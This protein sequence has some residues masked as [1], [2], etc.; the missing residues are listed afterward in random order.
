M[1]IGK[2]LLILL[3][4]ILIAGCATAPQQLSTIP[5]W[6][7][8]PPSENND[9]L[10]FTVSETSADSAGLEL[11]AGMQLYNKVVDLIG[12][13]LVESQRED[14][15]A[16]RDGI[17]GL[18][19]GG[20][21]SGFTLIEKQIVDSN[22]ES[23][24]FVLVKLEK[25][26]LEQ[27][28]NEFLDILRSGSTASIFSEDAEEF[29]KNGDLY[30]GTLSY[31]KAALESADSTNRFITEKNLL[32]AIEQLDKINIEKIDYPKSIA[33]GENGVFT[34]SM[35]SDSESDS[36]V[37]KNVS[38]KVTFLD[39]KKGSV[40]GERFA[41][42]RTD[43]YGQITFVHPSPGFT[44]S[45]RVS[46]ALDILRDIESLDIIKEN[47]SD[48]YEEL[49]AKTAEINVLYDFDIISSAPDVPTA[50]LI[51]D[52]DFL[53]NPL[54]S[55]NTAEGLLDNLSDAGFNVTI[56]N[57]DRNRL[58]N[59]S[60]REF[61][62]DIPYMVDSDIKRIVFGVARIS[63]FDDSAVGFTVVTEAEIRVLDLDTG[64]ILLEETMSKRVQGG[65]SQS[66]INTSFKELGK[67]F[68]SLLIDKL[69]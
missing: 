28:E 9:F 46:I 33:V 7:S 42:L 34:A 15:S 63:E 8:N 35:N 5:D 22:S 48:K 20:Q 61:L 2:F 38:V 51:I 54:D 45:G 12:L 14:L 52:S 36:S 44:G 1:R 56:V 43:E 60:E 47:Y 58:L 3:I 27:I 32:A 39:R 25:Q 23:T 55:V 68:S 29:V 17:I 53:R 66:T 62:R 6:F 10:Y 50:I 65:E 18:V 24:I 41:L 13:S 21:T 64:E 40:I 16:I 37:W 19:S 4:T 57:V 59:L 11:K 31:L 49:V 69:P 30:N 67:S 26:Q